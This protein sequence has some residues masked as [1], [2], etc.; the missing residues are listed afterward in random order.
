MDLAWNTIKLTLE[1]WMSVYFHSKFFTTQTVVSIGTLGK[2]C[3]V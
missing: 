3:T 2:T 1:T